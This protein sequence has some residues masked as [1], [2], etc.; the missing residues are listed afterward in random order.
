MVR[1]RWPFGPRKI[2]WW[3]ISIR[4]QARNRKNSRFHELTQ[5]YL[6]WNHA[7]SDISDRRSRQRRKQKFSNGHRAH[8]VGFGGSQNWSVLEIPVCFAAIWQTR[9]VCWNGFN[10]RD[11][12]SWVSI[13]PVIGTEEI[14]PAYGSP[15]EVWRKQ[16]DSDIGTR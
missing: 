10:H 14:C 13:I 3:K 8:H 6:A 9:S 4:F 5:W 7:V 12:P 11:H 15:R 2:L 16:I 1:S